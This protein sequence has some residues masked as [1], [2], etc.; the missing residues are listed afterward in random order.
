MYFF[1]LLV[2]FLITLFFCYVQ[3][4]CNLLIITGKIL[5]LLRILKYLQV[6]TLFVFFISF[7]VF[8]SVCLFFWR[9]FLSG[10]YC[11]FSLFLLCLGISSNLMLNTLYV[12]IFRF[13]CHLP[14]RSCKFLE[15]PDDVDEDDFSIIGLT[16]RTEQIYLYLIFLVNFFKL[17]FF[18]SKK[19]TVWG[20]N[21]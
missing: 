8:S 5:I 12:P 7:Y 18:F 16:N 10:F 2:S 13:R 15:L 3:I 9:L 19:K 21:L 20:R 6:V 1:Y 11:Y 14:K 17:K 4:I